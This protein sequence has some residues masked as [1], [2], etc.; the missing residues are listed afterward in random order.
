MLLR[1]HLQQANLYFWKIKNKLKSVY[2]SSIS[3]EHHLIE[4]IVIYNKS[5]LEMYPAVSNSII[6]YCISNECISEPCFYT[7]TH[8]YVSLW[9][10]RS[11]NKNRLTFSSSSILLAFC[12]IQLTTNGCKHNRNLT[13]ITTGQLMFFYGHLYANL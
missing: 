6:K 13:V 11:N 3:T 2:F 5:L 4:L 9:K 12:S 7:Q 10:Q 8:I 1:E